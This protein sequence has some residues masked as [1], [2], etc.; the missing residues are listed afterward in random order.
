MPTDKELALALVEAIESLF[1]ETMAY[2]ALL[3]SLKHRLPPEQQMMGLIE[4]AKNSRAI[5][6]EVRKQ[7]A[8]LRERILQ[9]RGLS[10]A[11]QEFLRVV[12]AKKDVN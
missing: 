12:P 9:D 8:P 11:I 4:Q 2:R 3:R 1:I 7:F 6:D 10:D 5:Q